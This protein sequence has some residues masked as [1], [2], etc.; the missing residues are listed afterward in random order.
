LSNVALINA[1]RVLV[2]QKIFKAS[3]NLKAKL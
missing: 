3:I 2:K 1:F